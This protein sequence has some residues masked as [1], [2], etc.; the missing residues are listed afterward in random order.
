MWAYNPQVALMPPAK[1]W[2][3]PRDDPP[4]Q[5]FTLEVWGGERQSPTKKS[6]FRDRLHGFCKD[7][8]R[9][10]AEGV[11][12][13]DQEHNERLAVEINALRAELLKCKQELDRENQKRQRLARELE[14]LEDFLEGFGGRP[15]SLKANLQS[16]AMQMVMCDFVDFVC[17]VQP[18]D[19]RNNQSS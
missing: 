1:L 9:L 3:I 5:L 4:D 12:A 10:H 2:R 8:E 14:N 18:P 16:V 13:K 6:A 19:E 15:G 17:V 7:F 11:H